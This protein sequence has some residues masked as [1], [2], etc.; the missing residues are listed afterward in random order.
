MNTKNKIK[1]YIIPILCIGLLVAFKADVVIFFLLLW[2][3]VVY[4]C[5]FLKINF[6][7][8]QKKIEKITKTLQVL[9]RK[10]FDVI[11]DP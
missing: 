6:Q 11:T 7:R 8:R 3:E 10:V 2:F 5:Y 9:F 4:D 1:I